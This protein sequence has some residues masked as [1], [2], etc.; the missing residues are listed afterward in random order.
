M[1]ERKVGGVM[2]EAKRGVNQVRGGTGEADWVRS[3][4]V[5]EVAWRA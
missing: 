5:G 4:R 2:G 1:A 3:G